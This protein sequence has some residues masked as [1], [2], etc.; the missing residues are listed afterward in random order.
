MNFAIIFRKPHTV[1]GAKHCSLR[2]PGRAGAELPLPSCTG[3]KASLLLGQAAVTDLLQASTESKPSSFVCLLFVC[4]ILF[5]LW[6]F[7][8]FW[9]FDWLVGV[10]FGLVFGAFF[11]F[12]FVF[13]S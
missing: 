4:L 7:G 11:L 6:L 10:C 9:L 1:A 12:I 2:S 8:F 3:R 13:P 5:F